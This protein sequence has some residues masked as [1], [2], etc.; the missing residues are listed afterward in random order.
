MQRAL[1][2]IR[3]NPAVVP[4]AVGVAILVAL[5]PAQAGYEP[6][7]W[8]PAAVGMLVLVV[9]SALV[10]PGRVS[11]VPRPVLFAVGLLALFTA[12]T[13]MSIVWADDQGAAW[14]SANRT[15]LYL[16]AFALFSLW[17]QSGTTAAILVGGW[18]LGIAANALIVLLRVS[19]A[20]NPARLFIDGRL[21]EPAGYVNA[22]AATWMMAVWPALVLASRRAVPWWLRGVFAGAA[23]LLVDVAILSQSRGA[24]F[25][26]PIVLLVL[27][28]LVPARVRT[29]AVLVPVVAGV[30]LTAREL[31]DLETRLGR[32]PDAEAVVGVSGP[33]LLAALGVAVVV[34]VAG[35]V[36]ERAGSREKAGRAHR[37][38]GAIAIAS[39]VVCVVGA[40]AIAG[41]PVDRAQDAW[42]SFKGG[43]SDSRGENRITGN[44]LGSNRYDFYRV[45]LD[46]FK[47]HPVDGT[48]WR[49]LP[50]AVP[51][52]GQE[53]RD[54]AVSPLVG[55]QDVVAVRGRRRPA[56][57][58]RV[59]SVPPS[60]S[61]PCDA[62]GRRAGVRDRRRPPPW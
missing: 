42:G 15:L 50:P 36:E 23:V 54:A 7:S 45:G 18:T 40:L 5:V 52:R 48:R 10:V 1:A 55:D 33:P 19:D 16:L 56:P 13:Y 25:S 38:G 43:Y 53:Q 62:P 34:T 35:L 44:G 21:V 49:Q 29:F 17:A 2:L 37:V 61:F 26:T 30:A 9:F 41:N 28:L 32:L 60:A 11:E 12:W 31:L 58:R 57:P 4:C 20:A 24:T 6:T 51:R 46:E 14:E 59:G 22:T 3:A 39:A 8:Y 47:A 27:F